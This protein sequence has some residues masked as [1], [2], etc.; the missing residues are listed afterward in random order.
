MEIKFDWNLRENGK[1]IDSIFKEFFGIGKNRCRI[2]VEGEN[3][4]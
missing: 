1:E 2:I 3:G 4:V